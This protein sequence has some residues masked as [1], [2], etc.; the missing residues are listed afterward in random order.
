MTA[1]RDGPV[2]RILYGDDGT[3]LP[4][5]FDLDASA[6]FGLQLC[7]I[8]SGQLGGTLRLER[9]R[10]TRFILEFPAG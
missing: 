4:E 1:L 5:S 9:D 7:S 6:G 2:V 10:G 3:G 8:L